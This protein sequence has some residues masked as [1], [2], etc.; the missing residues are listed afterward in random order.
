MKFSTLTLITALLATPVVAETSSR[1]PE[2]IG[3]GS[4]AALG[5]IVAGPVGV[6]VG[7]T[8]GTLMGHDVVTDRQLKAK[9]AELTALHS[10]ISQARSELA[11]L[12]AIQAKQHAEITAFQRLLSDLSVAVHFDVDSAMT[13]AE[14]R[15]AL[16]TVAAASNDIDGLTVRLVGH[17]DATGSMRYN[18]TLSDARVRSVGHVLT[19]AGMAAER[20]STEARG[21]RE[22]SAITQCGPNA[23]DRRV[24]IQLS[25]ERGHDDEGL[26]SIR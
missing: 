9:T 2:H 15:R 1:M 3:F 17:A 20:L 23:L 16:Q 12:N 8:L 6:V 13:A 10:E 5:G 19:E 24:D 14:Y 26:Y 7:G 25:F 18:E 11:R 21:E 22:A 4:G